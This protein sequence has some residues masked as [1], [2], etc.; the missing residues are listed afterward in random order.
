ME[1]HCPKKSLKDLKIPLRFV[2]IV[3]F[4]LQ[5]LGAVGLVGYLSYRSGQYSVEKLADELMIETSNRIQQHLDSYLG[6]V[7]EINRTNVDAF[8]SGILD[9]NDFNTLGKYFYRQLRAFNFAY[10]NF[11]S[12]EGGFVGAGYGMD[13]RLEI[14]EVRRSD[15]TTLY[16]Y[17]VNQQGDRLRLK[18]TSKN[19]QTHTS[20]WYLDAVRLGKPIWSSIYT[21][22]DSRNRISMS[23]ST[24]LYTP[25]KQLIG[26]LGID[27]EL[28][29][30][31]HFLQTLDR[32]S[33]SHIFIVERSGLIVASSEDEPPAFI[34]NNQTIRRKALNSREPVIREVTQDLIQRFGNLHAIAQPQSFRPLLNQNPFVRVIPYQ[35]QYGLDW[36][37]VIVIPESEFM[38]E[39]QTGTRTTISL[40]LLTLVIATGL[41]IITSNLIAAPILRLNQASR[42]IASGELSQVVEIK[43]VSE[44][45]S[46]VHSFNDMASQL[47]ASFQTLE[48]RVQERTSELIVAKNQLELLVNSDGLTQISNRRCFD[49]YLNVEWGRHQ[50]EQ[51]PLAVILIDIDYFKRYNDSNGHQMGDDC[52]IRVAQAIAKVPQR[53][54]DLVARYGG[55]EFAVILSNTHREGALKIAAGIQTAIAALKI[56]HQCSDVSNYITLS[57][58][59]ASLIPTSK[60]TPE[61]IIAYADQALYTAKNQGRNQAIAYVNNDLWVAA[62]WKHPN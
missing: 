31:S 34:D 47:Q 44:L 20:P 15:P 14:A 38:S 57:M 26:V 13:S 21:W 61:T 43:G 11:G 10:V 54:T 27:L 3:P 23:A 52:L 33:A 48:N 49:H 40:C 1:T 17:S 16:A 55:E 50:R 62:E 22:G 30:I 59:I 51:K 32:R 37:V 12:K 42:K 35:D 6:K 8:E 24:P 19:P 36:L 58:G 45:A 25:Q 29:Q 41:G 46:L 28:T 18:D 60:Q 39:I 4:V 7:Q 9:L 56:P 53:P 5:I 2:L